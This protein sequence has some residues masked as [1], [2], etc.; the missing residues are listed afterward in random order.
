MCIPLKPFRA[1]GLVTLCWRLRLL[2]HDAWSRSVQIVG[3]GQ[4]GGVL[5]ATAGWTNQS[6][7]CGLL[8]CCALLCECLAPWLLTLPLVCPPLCPEGTRAQMSLHTHAYAQDITYTVHTQSRWYILLLP[9]G[10]VLTR[11]VQE[12]TYQ[13][14]SSTA[15][16]AVLN[17]LLSSLFFPCFVLSRNPE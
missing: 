15:P 17:A 4:P 6:G 3:L 10:P 1:C 5:Q 7:L 8:L 16:K 11:R 9:S 14:V 13:S 12:H 2:K